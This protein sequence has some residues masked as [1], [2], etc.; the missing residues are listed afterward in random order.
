MDPVLEP[1]KGVWNKTKK[2]FDRGSQIVKGI[3]TIA[4]MANSG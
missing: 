1:I 2:I 4:D 3:G